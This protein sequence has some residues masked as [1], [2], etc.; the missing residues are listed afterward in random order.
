MLWSP[1]FFLPKLL[2]MWII[3]LLNIIRPVSV[4]CSCWSSWLTGRKKQ[5]NSLQLLTLRA[6]LASLLLVLAGNVLSVTLT[7]ICSILANHLPPPPPPQTH[8]LPSPHPWHYRVFKKYRPSWPNKYGG[9]GGGGC[10]R[11]E[12]GQQ[13]SPLT[14]KQWNWKAPVSQVCVCV[15]TLYTGLL[16]LCLT[17]TLTASGSQQNKAQ[18]STSSVCTWSAFR[19]LGLQ[20]QQPWRVLQCFSH[21]LH[22]RCLNTCLQKELTICHVTWVRHTGFP[23]HENLPGCALLQGAK[24]DFNFKFQFQTCTVSHHN[25]LQIWFSPVIVNC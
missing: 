2:C 13:D 8:T 25:K 7:G 20:S 23:R 14:P 10:C 22:H 24:P 5:N 3:I 9:G 1:F 21:K 11:K 15:T 6:L 12:V 17:R 19:I 4:T 16:N 18:T